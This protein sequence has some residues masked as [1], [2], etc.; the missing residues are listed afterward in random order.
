MTIMLSGNTL[1]I[2]QIVAVA[3]MR[4]KVHIDS[5]AFAYATLSH[6]FLHHYVQ[7]GEKI[8]G[9]SAGV[10]GNKDRTITKESIKEYNENSIRAHCAAVPPFYSE[11]I[12]RAAMLVRLNTL[13]LG[14][15]GIQPT[16]ITLL[17][18]ML[19]KEIHPVVPSRGSVGMADITTLAHI[20]LALI[21]EGEVIY[22]GKKTTTLEAFEKEK[23]KPVQCCC[24]DGLGI[25]SSNAFSAAHAALILHTI[26]NTIKT[27]EIIFSL[28]LEGLFS[29]SLS[30]LDKKVQHVRPFTGQNE[31]ASFISSILE[32][33]YL[34]D[35]SSSSLQDPLSFRCATQIFGAVR[36][37]L[38]FAK[39][40]LLIQLNSSDDNPCVLVEEE[41]ILPS[42][43]F[44]PLPWLL[45]FEQLAVGL[46]HISRQSCFRT[47]KLG[48][49]EFTGLSRYLSPESSVTVGLQNIQKTQ[50]ALDAQIRLLANPLS[51]DFYS[52]DS[53]MEDH[54]TNAP[55]VVQKIAEIINA[56]SYVLGIELIHSV[57]AIDLRKDQSRGEKIKEICDVV[58]E[59]IS[60]FNKDRPLS[61]DIDIAYNIVKSSKLLNLLGQV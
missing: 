32:N 44:N 15:A 46:S 22:K 43:N 39:E 50:T 12:V 59:H 37:L 17:Q 5:E 28:S 14:K 9:L 34:W 36:D 19:N 18:E 49:P 47:I 48:T 2:A 3:K 10:G 30:P 58:R 51:L 23:L 11:D 21:G 45:P 41:I 42:G 6:N 35:Y 16:I 55:G 1:T 27:A 57:Q 33:S 20:G 7:D 61:P 4:Q 8:Y 31:S 24:K 26:E 13:L 56:L 25:I 60:F 38:L 54:A 52:L 40:Q 29:G 53:E